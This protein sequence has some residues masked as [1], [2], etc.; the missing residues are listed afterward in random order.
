MN[1]KTT[2]MRRKR[3]FKWPKGMT[4]VFAVTGTFHGSIVE[5]KTEG[6]AKRMF[7]KAWN[8]ESITHCIDRTAEYL[9]DE[10]N[11]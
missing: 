9:L 1:Q 7:H 6:E 3:K 8:G 11:W 5:A 4:R 10:I 2:M